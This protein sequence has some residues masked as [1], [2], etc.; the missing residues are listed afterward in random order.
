MADAIYNT[1]MIDLRSTTLNAEVQEYILSYEHWLLML[2]LH[3]FKDVN[4]KTDKSKMQKIIDEY[5]Y[6]IRSW[7]IGNHENSTIFLIHNQVL[8]MI[9][10][11][12]LDQIIYEIVTL[13]T[14][15]DLQEMLQNTLKLDNLSRDQIQVKAILDGLFCINQAIKF[16]N[17]NGITYK[18]NHFFVANLY[19]YMYKWCDYLRRNMIARQNT[20]C[21]CSNED[22]RDYLLMVQDSI[23]EQLIAI[24]GGECE[25][26]LSPQY[27]LSK[28]QEHF[29]KAI[30]THQGGDY[31]RQIISNMHCLHEDFGS[32]MYHFFAALDRILLNKAVSI[33]W[34]KEIKNKMKI[35]TIYQTKYFTNIPS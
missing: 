24:F 18:T 32:D 10:Y 16:V 15:E 35:S 29:V 21:G 26:L 22:I 34:E 8:K 20:I 25:H 12:L 2:L 30:D 17:I 14:D 3:K 7:F 27:Y 11:S 5:R 33:G 6:I 31:Y 1:D 9:N 28:A 23:R 19:K 4:G 13:T